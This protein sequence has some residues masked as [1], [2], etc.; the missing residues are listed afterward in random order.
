MEGTDPTLPPLDP[1]AADAGLTD[2]PAASGA[3]AAPEI[4]ASAPA[5]FD[6]EALARAN[7]AALSPALQ[8]FAPKPE[9][10]RAPWQDPA[11]FNLK[12][13]E[14]EAALAEYHRRHQSLA[15]AVADQKIEA[16]LKKQREEFNAALMGQSQYFNTLY[17]PTH[18]PYRSQLDKYIRKGYDRD[19]AV[20]LAKQDAGLATA[21]A[22]TTA[23]R[24]TPM[25]PRHAT[26]PATRNGT[27]PAQNTGRKPMLVKGIEG[28][29]IRA[30]EW[31]AGPGASEWNPDENDI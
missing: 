23:P 28:A 31:L 24:S 18:T 4:A 26:G 22:G 20:R 17:D 1:P 11:H 12:G 2:S 6:Y 13:F 15:E 14:G 27:A 30:R 16:A 19:D 29:K 7:A 3:E 8:A 25:P 5:P 9:Q 21:P 10:V